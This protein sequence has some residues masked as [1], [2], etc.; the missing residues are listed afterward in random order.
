MH[1]SRLEDQLRSALRA[2]GEGLPLTITT[3]ELERRLALRRRE[4]NG[5]RLTLVAAGIAVVAVGSIVAFGNGWLRMPAV[6]V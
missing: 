1:D 6:G 2:D 5:L 3:D 4:R